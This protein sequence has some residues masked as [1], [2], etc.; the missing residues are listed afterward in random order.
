MWCIPPNENAEFVANM[1]DVL[2]VYAR[3]YDED[4]PVVCMDEKPYQLL[5]DHIAPLVMDENNHKRRYDCEYERKGSCAIFMFAEPLKGQRHVEALPQRRK[6]DWAQQVKR[7]LD[8][9][10][11]DAKKVV[12][13]LDNLNTHTMSSLYETFP[14]AEAFRLAQRLEI[15]YTPKHGSWLN[16]AEIEL[17]ALSTQCLLGRR[18]PSISKLNSILTD[19]Y[20][21]TNLNQRGVD[22]RFNTSDARIKLKHLYPVAK[23]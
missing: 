16:M 23:F 13:V 12:F 4:Y 22:W 11:P 9:D 6:I 14:A 5:D 3:P 18:I 7:L 10:Y 21:S 17:S 1:E 2:S 8:E 19:W 20:T 15:H